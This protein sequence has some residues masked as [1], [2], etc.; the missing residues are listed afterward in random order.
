MRQLSDLEYAQVAEF[1]DLLYVL[2]RKYPNRPFIKIFQDAADFTGQSI[3]NG[4]LN[5]QSFLEML[6]RYANTHD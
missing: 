5:N 4:A 3:W 1:R 6:Q 2:M